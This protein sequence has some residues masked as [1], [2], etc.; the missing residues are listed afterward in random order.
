MIVF[1]Q[2]VDINF[3]AFYLQHRFIT[4]PLVPKFVQAF[5]Q[6]WWNQKKDRMY[7]FTVGFKKT[8]KKDIFHLITDK[9]VV[10][11]ILEQNIG[12]MEP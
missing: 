8:K 5:S 2:E 7:T 1:C 12:R 9:E 10:V 11:V 3:L 6:Q 4:F